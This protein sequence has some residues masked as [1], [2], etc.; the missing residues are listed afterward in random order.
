MVIFGGGGG[1]N[2]R[3]TRDASGGLGTFCF[4]ISVLV[5]WVCS[6]VVIHQASPLKS[7]HV[8]EWMLSRGR[9]G[10]EGQ[11]EGESAI[12]SI[13]NTPESAHALPSLLPPSPHYCLPGSLQ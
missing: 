13:Q 10:R 2:G 9:K 4:F 3:I 11:E 12:P 7:V 8:S 1:S 5:P 6:V